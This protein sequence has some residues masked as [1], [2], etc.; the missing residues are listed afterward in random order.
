MQIETRAYQRSGQ[1]VT[2]FAARL[3]AVHSDFA[4]QAL[5][6]P[7]LFDFLGL[8]NEANERDTEQGLTQHITRFLLEMGAGFAFIGRQVLVEVALFFFI[9]H[10]S[11][12]FSISALRA[13]F[14]T[15]IR[16]RWA[17]LG[18]WQQTVVEHGELICSCIGS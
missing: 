1:A 12:W 3:P 9:P 13:E 2:N 7:Y 14:R 11:I 5:K 16:F 17:R 10:D 18:I 8:S 4:R 6:D 15:G